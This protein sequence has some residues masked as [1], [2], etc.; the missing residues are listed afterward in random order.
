M[1]AFPQ[2]KVFS[3]PSISDNHR[4]VELGVRGEPELAERAFTLIEE[5]LAELNVKYEKINH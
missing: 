1:Q 5:G 2:V 4:D 3:L